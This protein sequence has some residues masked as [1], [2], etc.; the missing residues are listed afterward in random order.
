VTKL[1]VNRTTSKVLYDELK[2]ALAF[3][4]TEIALIGLNYT[5]L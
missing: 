4:S 5:F 3:E 1:I 2:K